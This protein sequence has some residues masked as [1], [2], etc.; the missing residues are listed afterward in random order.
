MTDLEV[1]SSNASIVNN[2][3]YTWNNIDEN[4]KMNFVAKVPTTESSTEPMDTDYSSTDNS[5][6]SYSDNTNANDDD[7][8]NTETE[9]DGKGISPVVIIVSLF[10]LAFVGLVGAIVLK[11][12]KSTINKI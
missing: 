5:D 4:F 6:D 10:G 8:K 11:A 2:N 3:V 12:K 9:K 1:T 7:N